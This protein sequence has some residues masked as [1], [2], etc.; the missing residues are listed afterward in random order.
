MKH[1]YRTGLIAPAAVGLVTLIVLAAAG[2]VWALGVLGI[3]ALGV[4]LFHVHHIQL[5]T[6]WARGGLDNPVPVGRGTWAV[7]FAAIHRR[8]RIRIAHQRELK[9]VI[10]R[11]REAAEAMPDGVVALDEANRVKW[12]NPKALDQLGLD[13]AKDSN[14]PIVNIVRHPEFLAYLE[15]RDY[16]EA[17]VLQS[18]R[19]GKTLS[20]QIVPFAVD[21]KLVISRDVTQVEAVARMRRDFIANV[22]HE[23]KTP[24]TVI[25]GFLETLQELELDE[26]QR[27]RYMQLMQEQSKSME[28]LV[29]DLL[30]LSALESEQNPLSDEAFAIVPL[31]LQISSDAKALSQRQHEVK[32]DIHD[33][34]SVQ[35]SRDEL[36]SAFGNLVSNAIRYTPAGGT[37]TLSWCVEPDGVGVFAVTDTGIGIGPEH[38]PR[39]TERFYRIDRS[40][41]RATGGTGLGL[42]IV[43]HVLLR[44]Q[45]ELVVASEPGNGSTFS[46]RLPAR[47]VRR[48]P[49]AA[50]APAPVTSNAR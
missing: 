25:T 4:I 47:R 3:G 33:A 45:A 1:A 7:A 42:A 18:Y 43:K 30:T 17:L 34:A 40:R 24:L 38:L 10:E 6:D 46:V 15:E 31:M 13:L 32:L 49:H 50:D 26:R 23:L 11:F 14:Q 27:T 37:I 16:R 8:A 9:Q 41:S 20:M 35:G 19:D 2:P 44:H 48:T 5:L 36:A 39:L 22:S 28:R 21:E 29:E 12:A